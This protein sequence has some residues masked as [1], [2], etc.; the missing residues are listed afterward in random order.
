MLM[1]DGEN[2]NVGGGVGDGVTTGA[3]VGVGDGAGVIV[4]TIGVGVGSGAGVTYT[5]TMSGCEPAP[6]EHAA[7]IKTSTKEAA[8]PRNARLYTVRKM[9]ECREGQREQTVHRAASHRI[10]ECR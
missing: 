2:A 4:T 7:R 3:N 9:L 5:G 8:T 10:G 6:E 1:L